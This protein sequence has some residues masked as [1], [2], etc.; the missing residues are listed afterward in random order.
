MRM[1]GKPSPF[2]FDEEQID[3]VLRALASTTYLDLCGV[4]MFA[5]TQILDATVLLAQWRH[6]IEVAAHVARATRRPLRSIDLGGGLGIPYYAGDTSLDLEAV[7]S[8]IRR[9]VTDQAG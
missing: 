3:D 6:G 4:H 2:G 5:G 1:G 7:Q 8:G 9:R